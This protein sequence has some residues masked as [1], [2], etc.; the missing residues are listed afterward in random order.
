[1]HRNPAESG[2]GQE[3]MDAEKGLVEGVTDGRRGEENNDDKGEGAHEAPAG[4]GIV[5]ELVADSCPAEAGVLDV[6]PGEGVNGGF[7]DDHP[8]HPAVDEVVGVETDL[9]DRD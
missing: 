5:D 1:M 6:G 2:H 3:D 8:S 7:E 9:E 4:E